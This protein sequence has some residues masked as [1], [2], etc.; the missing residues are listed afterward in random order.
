MN[1]FASYPCPELSA[2][3]L[4]DKR[5]MKMI[6][7]SAQLLCNA[8]HVVCPKK[9]ESWM[10]KPTHINHPCSMWTRESGANFNW[11]WLHAAHLCERYRRTYHKIHKSASIIGQLHD[12]YRE[13]P[14]REQTEFPN[15]TTVEHPDVSYCYR[16]YLREKWRNDKRTPTRNKKSIEF[17][18]Q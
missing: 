6:V 14:D 5:A 10:Y 15:C 17:E 8:V 16:E 18:L 13:M 9:V 1:I 4:D 3:F 7:E 12:F 2:G 11:L